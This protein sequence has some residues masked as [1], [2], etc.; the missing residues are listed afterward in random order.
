[1]RSTP[2]LR[3]PFERAAASSPSF[4]SLNTSSWTRTSCD[5]LDGFSIAFLLKRQQKFSV[6]RQPSYWK[7]LLQGG[8][9]VVEFE[10]EEL[11]SNA[12]A[13][14]EL[15]HRDDEA[16][17]KGQQCNLVLEIVGVQQL[18]QYH[19]EPVA[20]TF[21]SLKS[22]NTK[23]YKPYWATLWICEPIFHNMAQSAHFKLY[24]V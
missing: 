3:G 6:Q 11:I 1:L 7:Y 15:G 20:L 4:C 23:V 24:F 22:K 18:A 5:S 8:E 14:L 16:V 2:E 12:N 13:V 19:F 10:A 9:N 17:D 21:V